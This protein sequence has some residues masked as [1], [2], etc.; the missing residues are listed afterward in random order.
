M[1][2]E[3]PSAGTPLNVLAMVLAAIGELEAEKLV[4]KRGARTPN[5][6]DVVTRLE[7]V[8]VT[9]GRPEVVETLRVAITDLGLAT[10]VLAAG[11][12]GAPDARS[13]HVTMA[14]VRW[15]RS[16]VGRDRTTKP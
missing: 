11:D 13:L 12:D 3:R 10:G 7:A 16:E 14:G 15:L 9:L 4:S 6:T 8:G 1:A 5:A 2:A